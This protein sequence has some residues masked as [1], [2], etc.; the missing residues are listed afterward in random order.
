MPDLKVYADFQCIKYRN[1][2]RWIRTIT[3]T[4]YNM[5]K[6]ILYVVNP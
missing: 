1:Y 5:R 3:E 4:M 2:D 6:W